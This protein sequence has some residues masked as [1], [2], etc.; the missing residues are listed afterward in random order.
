M[1][2]APYCKRKLRIWP[3]DIAAIYLA[4]ELGCLSPLPL[5]ELAHTDVIRCSTSIRQKEKG[6]HLFTEEVLPKRAL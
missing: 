3:K 4:F 6:T 2:I 1:W 5:I